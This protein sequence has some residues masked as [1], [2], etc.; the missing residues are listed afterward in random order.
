MNLSSFAAK[1]FL[2]VLLLGCL[3]VLTKFIV[4]KNSPSYYKNYF[5][6]EFSRNSY[7][8]GLA[9]AN[10]KPFATLKLMQNSHL[11]EEYKIANLAGN[12]AGFVPLGILLPL[13]F[14]FLRSLWKTMIAVFFISLGFETVQLVTDLGIFDVDD[15]ILNTTGGIAG[16]LLYAVTRGITGAVKR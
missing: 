8:K 3:L 1:F 15:L 11:R 2:S 5:R 6:A 12:V 7:K 10:F 4:F 9:K 14:P 13:L 16:Y